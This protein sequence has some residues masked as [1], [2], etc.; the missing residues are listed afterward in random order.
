MV[1]I[2]LISLDHG[3]PIVNDPARKDVPSTLTFCPSY[4]T[5]WTQASSQVE[6]LGVRMRVTATP[7]TITTVPPMKARLS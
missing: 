3:W 2:Q 1:S 4:F 6:N 7:M 5:K